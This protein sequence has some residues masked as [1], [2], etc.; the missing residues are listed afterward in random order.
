LLRWG[1]SRVTSASQESTHERPGQHRAV[2]EEPQPDE[3]LVDLIVIAILLAEP[4]RQAGCVGFFH[5]GRQLGECMVASESCPIVQRQLS[6]FA[7]RTEPLDLDD[8]SFFGHRQQQ[9]FACRSL[10]H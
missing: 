2:D 9:L 8:P 10:D 5:G 1:L 7:V 4:D 3:I 6:R